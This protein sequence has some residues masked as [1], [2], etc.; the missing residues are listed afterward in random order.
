VQDSTGQSNQG[1]GGRCA[2]VKNQAP[3]LELILRTRVVGSNPAG[4]PT[5]SILGNQTKSSSQLWETLWDLYP[6]AHNYKLPSPAVPA[7][8][9]RWL[10]V[11]STR[12]SSRRQ[13]E[14][15]GLR[16]EIRNLLL[17]VIGIASL[18]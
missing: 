3:E 16:S 4:A 14:Q 13:C 15:A 17:F 7:T 12:R 11:Q 6:Q 18:R 5:F 9:G 10:S 8:G 1:T 2:S